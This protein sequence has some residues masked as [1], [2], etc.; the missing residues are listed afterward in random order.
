MS[1]R[2]QTGASDQLHDDAKKIVLNAI[3]MQFLSVNWIRGDFH[4][5]IKDNIEQGVIS[6]H[7]ADLKKH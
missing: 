2:R 4:A 7:N 3:N 6:H 1:A 5:D